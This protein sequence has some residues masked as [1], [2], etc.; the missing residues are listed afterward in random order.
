MTNYA[1]RIAAVLVTV[2]AIILPLFSYAPKLYRWLV[3]TRLSAMYRRLRTVEANL[4]NDTT[5]VEVSTLEAELASVDRA[6]HMLSV[7]MQHSDLFFSIKSHLDLVRVQLG[8]RRAELQAGLKQ[9]S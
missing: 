6:I 8:L 5:G 3:E 9:A 4:H 2:I 7:P 1:Q